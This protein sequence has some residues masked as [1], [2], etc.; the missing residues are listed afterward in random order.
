MTGHVS[1]LGTRTD[2]EQQKEFLTDLKDAAG[3]GLG[4]VDKAA[5]G[6]DL[7][8]EDVA[9]PWAFYRG[10]IDRAVNDCVNTMAPKWQSK[11]SAFDVWIFDQCATMEQSIRVD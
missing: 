10:Y 3:K 1:R 7:R 4:A 11:L 6:A 9:N 5:V 2:V 8:P